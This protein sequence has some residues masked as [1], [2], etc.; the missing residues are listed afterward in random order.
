MLHPRIEAEIARLSGVL[1]YDPKI[2]QDCA[3]VADG[4]TL[5]G[6]N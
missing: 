3:D 5:K 1:N 4:K 2:L 6:S